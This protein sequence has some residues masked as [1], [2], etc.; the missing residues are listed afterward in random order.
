MI[1]HLQAV[2]KSVTVL[3]RYTRAQYD[4]HAK[5]SAHIAP[6]KFQGNSIRSLLPIENEE[7][8]YEKKLGTI[9]LGKSFALQAPSYASETFFEENE[10]ADDQ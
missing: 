1:I 9:L 3:Q 5:W 8:S 4:I 6:L 7:S 10:L 2:W